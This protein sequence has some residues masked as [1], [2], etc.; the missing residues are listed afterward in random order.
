M[1][2]LNKNILDADVKIFG[3]DISDLS[4]K[5]F[6][7]EKEGKTDKIR[8]YFSADIPRGNIEDG[9][10]V[11]KEV[12]INCIKK[13]IQ[14]S[15]PKKINTNKVVCSLPESKA[16]LRI[17]NIPK[18]GEE[19]AGEAVKWE[20]EANIPMSIDQVYFDWQ[21][22][23][24][25]EA[26]GKGEASQKQS[27]LTVAVSKDIV[28]DLM[29]VLGKAGLDVYGLEVESIASLR[30]LIN[31][32]NNDKDTLVID[33][34]AQRTSFIIA[35]SGIPYFTSSIPFSSETLNE[36]MIQSLHLN[37]GEAERTKIEQGIENISGKNTVFEAV[38]P[39]LEYLVSEIEKTIDFYFG[40]SKG[41][42]GVNKIIL[43]G[44]GSNLKG[45]VSYLAEK[46]NKNVEI[47]NP[48]INLHLGKQKI[49]IREEEAIR[50]CTAIGLALR[51]THYGN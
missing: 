31:E 14:K 35:R 4:I 6:Q 49:K 9:K 51:G 45:L 26:G 1:S 28:D 44:G 16:F 23:E 42:L 40:I 37:P 2:V 10:I 29:E 50:Y 43:C 13:A 19:E 17:I 15:G 36:S 22:L 32:K 38:K 41:S 11:N 5:V 33:F 18:M 47:G 3:L 39:M 12:V 46:L 24:N 25:N 27:V 20:M 30:S 34:G 7:L 8:S 48:W 21:F